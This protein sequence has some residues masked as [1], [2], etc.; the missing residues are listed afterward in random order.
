[1]GKKTEKTSRQRRKTKGKYHMK[2]FSLLYVIREF[3]SE[4]PSRYISIPFRMA[5][6]TKHWHHKM[7]KGCGTT[8]IHIHC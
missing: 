4:T 6:S 8:G 1:M 3:Q 2:I 7:L 5:K